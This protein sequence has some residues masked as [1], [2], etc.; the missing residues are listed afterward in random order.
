MKIK[1][2]LRSIYLLY[3]RPI[4][5]A[6]SPEYKQ[7]IGTLTIKRT[8]NV[9]DLFNLMSKRLE[10]DIPDLNKNLQTRAGTRGI[11]R[12]EIVLG[13]YKKDLIGTCSLKV[14]G[15]RLLELGFFVHPKYRGQGVGQTLVIAG[16]EYAKKVNFPT[17]YVKIRLPNIVSQKVLKKMG[18]VE[19]HRD[20]HTVFMRGDVNELNQMHK[21]TKKH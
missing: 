15:Y 1:D 19:T 4:F 5:M 21:N 12:K 9:D 3:Y 2:L 20:K 8:T 17:L 13:A 6:L 7:K 16:T 10:D 14:K 11:L 18:F